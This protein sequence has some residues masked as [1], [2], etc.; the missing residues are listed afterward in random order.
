MSARRKCT[1]VQCIGGNLSNLECRMVVRIYFFRLSGS[2]RHQ[3]PV[4][5]DGNLQLACWMTEGGEEK[6]FQGCFKRLFQ[7]NLKKD[8]LGARVFD[9]SE[10]RG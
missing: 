8:L 7:N 2:A 6:L 1:H 4:G 5:V 10:I 3:L 9:R